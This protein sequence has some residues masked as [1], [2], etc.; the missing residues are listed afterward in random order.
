M[1][2]LRKGPTRGPQIRGWSPATDEADLEDQPETNAPQ[3]QPE[4][5]ES[6]LPDPGLSDLSRHD[7][8]A[9]LKRA[10]KEALNANITD[11]A[12]AL[13]YY[14]FLAIPSVLLVVVGAF[15]LVASPDAI[16][17]LMDQFGRV[18]PAETTTLIGES[19]TRLNQ[20]QSSS[21]VM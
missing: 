8:L 20:N 13:S 3:P 2:L 17:T 21:L 11:L 4:R 16:A 15:T 1:R 7:Y 12:A 6:R 19:L 18:M 5:R 9:A 10:G 14:S